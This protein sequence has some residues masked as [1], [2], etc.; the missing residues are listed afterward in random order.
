MGFL[1][2]S[3]PFKKDSVND[4]QG[5]LVPLAQAKRHPLVIEAYSKRRFAEGLTS[6]S[7]SSGTAVA[8]LGDTKA[9]AKE[10]EPS[11][12]EEGVVR[13]SSKLYCPYTVEGLKAEVLEDVSARGEDSAYDRECN[14]FD[15]V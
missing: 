13:T 12:G 15:M 4:Y 3:K 2:L 9:E 1:G 8:G 14:C 7:A 6:D 10:D 11:G 5:V